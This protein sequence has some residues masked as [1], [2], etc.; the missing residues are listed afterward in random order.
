MPCAQERA[1]RQLCSGLQSTVAALLL[2]PS[3]VKHE[4]PHNSL[5]YAVNLGIQPSSRRAMRAAHRAAALEPPARQTG[6]IRH[7][8]LLRGR[9]RRRRAAGMLRRR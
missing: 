3:T 7:H 2:E 6:H 8:I 9:R 1:I 4:V 5:R